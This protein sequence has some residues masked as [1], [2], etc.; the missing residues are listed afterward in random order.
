MQALEGSL[1][2]LS[3]SG[4]IQLLA[5]EGRTGRL[6]LLDDDAVGR[7]GLWLEAGCLVHAERAGQGDGADALFSLLDAP[8]G[9]FRFAAGASAPRRTLD[10]TVDELLLE[11]ACRRDHAGRGEAGVPHSAVPRLAPVPSSGTTPR[12]NTL[13]WRVLAAV[14]G[15]RDVAGV[16]DALQLPV[17]TVG[18]LLRELLAAGVLELA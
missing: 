1:S 6:D 8:G 5:S 11:A 12:F 14:D 13:Q 18:A 15:R 2:V 9:Q 3:L 16:A 4:L 17:P 7:G 10:G